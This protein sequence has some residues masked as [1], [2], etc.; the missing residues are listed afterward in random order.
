ML[1]VV[2]T[3]WTTNCGCEYE[4]VQ[5]QLNRIKVKRI[6]SHSAWHHSSDH[7]FPPIAIAIARSHHHHRRRH[8]RHS[9]NYC[10]E[11]VDR[12][13]E[14]AIIFHRFPLIRVLKPHK[15][16][17]PSIE[18]IHSLFFRSFVWL[19]CAFC[20]KW[21]RTFGNN[22]RNTRIHTSKQ[23]I[24][25]TPVYVSVCLCVCVVSAKDSNPTQF[26]PI[27]SNP[28]N[29]FLQMWMIELNDEIAPH[30]IGGKK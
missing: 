6:E 15:G 27:Q 20:F 28:I 23:Q 2:G 24:I 17:Q 14:A 21:W 8:H 30:H 18:S 29:Y 4:D 10:I 16:G 22:L 26:N 13:I 25:S 11:W 7:F 3:N 12:T 5:S 9:R 19:Y 1:L